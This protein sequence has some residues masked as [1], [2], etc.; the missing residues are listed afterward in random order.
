MNNIEIK[1]IMKESRFFNYEIASAIGIT[2][3]SF[4]KWFRKQLTES[5]QEAIL[6]A[7]NKLKSGTVNE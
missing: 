1:K 6:R 5:Q 7:I 2:E 3:I 4:S